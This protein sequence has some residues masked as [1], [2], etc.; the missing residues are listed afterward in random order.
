MIIMPS[1][2]A[3]HLWMLEVY[4]RR[5]KYGLMDLSIKLSVLTGLPLKLAQSFL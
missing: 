1:L 5:I 4:S 2:D 3:T